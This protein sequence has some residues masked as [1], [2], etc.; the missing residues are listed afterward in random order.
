MVA[1]KKTTNRQ[2]K[3]KVDWTCKDCQNCI[4][5]TEFHT[6]SLKGEPTLGT[7]KFWNKSKCVLLSLDYCVDNFKRK[8]NE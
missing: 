7:C 1:R 3:V 4:Q 6:L 8:E 5:V 2:K